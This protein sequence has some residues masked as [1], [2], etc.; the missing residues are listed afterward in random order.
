MLPTAAGAFRAGIRVTTGRAV[1][2]RAR[3]SFLD[4]RD[5]PARRGSPRTPRSRTRAPDPQ[6]ARTRQAILIVGVAI[7]LFVLFFGIRGCRAAQKEQ[8]F[9]DYVR[10]VGGIVQDSERQSDDFF[11]L[12]RNPGDSSAVE[13]QNRVNEFRGEADQLVERAGEV[14]HPG[15]LDAAHRYLVD[16]L[17]FRRDGLTRIAR[18]L[19]TALGQEGRAEARERIAAQMQAFLASDVVYSQRFFPRTATE[20]DDQDLGDEV[21]VPP[22]QFLPD[23]EWLSPTVVAD[24]IGRISGG[25]GE[26]G[27]AAPGLHGTGLV[28]VTVKPAGTALTEGG[29][30][31]IPAAEDLS[32]DVQLQNQGENDEQDVTVTV[33]IS[34]AG[35]PIR[36]EDSIDAIAAGETQTISVPLAD[37]PPTGRPVTIKVE[38]QAVPGEEKTDNNVAEYPAVFTEG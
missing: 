14:D 9:K 11:G 21:E 29:A 36:V 3:V 24:R 20:L 16:T 19:P 26:D 17:A 22:S 23:L 1:I 18:D 5:A 27:T 32:F 38:I 7:L 2:L 4:E 8:A 6:T 31:E 25:G 34:G 37:T 35:E 33:E 13:I 10:D 12:L 28:S 30:A 15:E